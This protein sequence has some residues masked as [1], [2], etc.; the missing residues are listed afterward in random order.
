LPICRGTNSE[1]RS[2]GIVE[3]TASDC[4]P[5]EI[6]LVAITKKRLKLQPRLHTLLQ[7]VEVNLFEKIYI[8]QLV[9]KALRQEIMTETRN[10]LNLFN[11]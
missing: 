5:V 3:I 10:Q 8:I 9:T 11:S 7:I 1:G 2:Q 4:S 6:S